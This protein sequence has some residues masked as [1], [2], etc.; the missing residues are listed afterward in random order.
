MAA[1][2]SPI[3][4]LA[5]RI[6][7][8]ASELISEFS[9][10]SK[11][12]GTHATAI[13]KSVAVYEEVRRVAE[14][15]VVSL[16]KATVETLRN[17]DATYKAA[18]SAGMATETFSQLA[19]AASLSGVSVES[20]G[21]AMS[22]LNRNVVDAA[23]GTGTGAAAFRA[24][25][26][27]VE[28]AGGNL[29][30]ADQIV[31]EMADKFAGFK[32][33][34]EKSA[35][36]IAVFGRAGAQMIPMLNQGAEGVTRLREEAK[37]LGVTI[38]TETGKAAEEFNDNVSRIGAAAHGAANQLMRELLPALTSVADTLVN[39]A[40]ESGGFHD[41]IKALADFLQGSAITVFQT[42]AVLGSNLAFVFKQMGGEIGVIAAQLTLMAHG[43][44]KG[45][46]LI[47]DEWTKDSEQARKDLDAFQKRVMD[48]HKTVAVEA[49]GA[50]DMGLGG[51]ASAM[52][53]D[54]GAAPKLDNNAAAEAERIAKQLQEGEDEWQKTL[55]EAAAAT[56]QYRDQQI[57]KEKDFADTRN[58]IL[59]DAADAAEE[60]AIKQGALMQELDADGHAQKLERLQA[61]L[62]G[63][64]A[65]EQVAYD[66]RLQMLQTFTDA[67]LE[68]LGGRHAVEE[69]MEQ[70]HRDRMFQIQQTNQ[71]K[72]VAML[73][74]FRAGDLKN[75]TGALAEM[76]AGLS[77]K[78]RQ[79]FEINKLASEANIIVKGVD[80]VMSSYSWGASWG[81]PPAG[82][83]SAAVAAA[84]SLA[85]LS[86][87]H[88]AQFGGGTAPSV[89]GSTAA[90]AVSDVGGGSSGGNGG[91]GGSR[92]VT[93]ITIVGDTFGRKQV[94]GLLESLNDGLADG[95]RLI[96]EGNS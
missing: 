85:Q 37:Q 75:A 52:G 32:D 40:K 93:A 72:T 47:G 65:A 56:V 13:G 51:I 25:G 1:D 67:E 44:F 57:A 34:P 61:E 48:V 12:A 84:F 46:R 77:T 92:Q 15:V 74:A 55:S 53:G 81:G 58:K 45:A 33:G 17:A 89:A 9:K 49:G 10:A 26:I 21:V 30:S 83:A 18:Q 28:D 4:A 80:A 19:Y 86:A 62:D 27:Q 20:L 78:S 66:M 39:S 24:L 50:M 59:M 73:A 68:A 90:P 41:E 8:D 23:S 96:I 29:K 43:D 38:D 22:R 91:G 71:G 14:R 95:G 35:L 42:V 6:G 88:S 94:R 3:G 36:A 54:K 82:V 87:V 5:V 11:A 63:G 7:A 76:T 64:L 16:A 31:A 2:G 79:M 69:K 70:A 60:L